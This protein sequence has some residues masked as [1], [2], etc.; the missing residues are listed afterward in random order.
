MA[1]IPSKVLAT[2]FTGESHR[3]QVRKFLR[4]NP[5]GEVYQVANVAAGI[6]TDQVWFDDSTEAMDELRRRCQTDKPKTVV[7]M[8]ARK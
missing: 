1:R 3:V 6:Y 5:E 2:G 8:P 4:T 7:R